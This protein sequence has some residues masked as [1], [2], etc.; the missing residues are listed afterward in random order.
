MFGRFSTRSTSFPS[1]NLKDRAWVMGLMTDSP[2]ERSGFQNTRI[3]G[4]LRSKKRRGKAR[5]QTSPKSFCTPKSTS[6]TWAAS[7][8]LPSFQSPGCP[9]HVLHCPTLPFPPWYSPGSWSSTLS[10]VLLPPSQ[11]PG[12]FYAFTSVPTGINWDF[13]SLYSTFFKTKTGRGRNGLTKMSQQQFWWQFC[14]DALDFLIQYLR[15]SIA[16]HLALLIRTHLAN[17]FTHIIHMP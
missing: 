5:D 4:K 11:C 17:S 13:H 16:P 7:C 1:S 9:A 12:H 15:C 6:A 2:L 14:G 10:S 8:L 3:T